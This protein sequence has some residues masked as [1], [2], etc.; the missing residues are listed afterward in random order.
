M[1]AVGRVFPLLTAGSYVFLLR[2]AS[3]ICAPDQ[4]AAIHMWIVNVEF[5]GILW[6]EANILKNTAEF[7]PEPAIL[8]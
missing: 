6:S 4:C 5:C 3:V 2:A 7:I 8:P 1:R